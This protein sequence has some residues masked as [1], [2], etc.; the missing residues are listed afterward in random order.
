MLDDS[1][2]PPGLDPGEV[3]RRGESESGLDQQVIGSTPLGPAHLPE[4]VF[5]LRPD[6]A[7]ILAKTSLNRTSTA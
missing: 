2:N 7:E 3:R 5:I 1:L 6:E 4:A